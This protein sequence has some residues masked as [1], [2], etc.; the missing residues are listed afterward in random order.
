[1]EAH[2]QDA[3][4]ESSYLAQVH[5]QAANEAALVKTVGFSDPQLPGTIFAEN[6]VRPAFLADDEI[7]MA[8]E[9]CSPEFKP[10]PWEQWRERLNG[11][12]GGHR[13]LSGNLR[14]R[15]ADSQGY[16][17][18]KRRTPPLVEVRPDAIAWNRA[19]LSRWP[20]DPRTD[21]TAFERTAT[22][23]E[24]RGMSGLF[25]GTGAILSALSSGDSWM[26][27]EAMRQPAIW[28]LGLIAMLGAAGLILLIYQI[29]PWFER[30]FE[31]T[32][33]VISYLAHR[34]HHLRRGLSPLRAGSNRRRGPRPCRPSCS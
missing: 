27:S 1:M 28:L 20:G 6:N 21:L 3:V 17:A 14:C 16:A 25:Q 8:E 22:Q 33:M 24:E 31:S 34:R 32:V 26:L 18:R 10:E 23:R 2:L 9:M 30:N 29:C 12:A 13:H 19:A 11:W 4:M 7:K 15:A 5:V